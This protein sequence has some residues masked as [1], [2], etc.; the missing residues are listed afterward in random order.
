M[1]RRRERRKISALTTVT[2][3]GMRAMRPARSLALLS[4]LTAVGQ[5]GVVAMIFGALAERTAGV[6][7][8]GA[9]ALAF[10]LL[11]LIRHFLDQ[12]AGRRA[13]AVGQEVVHRLRG[14]VL[15]LQSRRS[16]ALTERATSAA[17]AT[18]VGQG[19]DQLLPWFTRYAMAEIRVYVMPL[20]ILAILLP[21]SWVAALI[22]IMTGP[23]IP[24]FMALIGYA[25]RDATDLQ[26]SES[27][28]LNSAVL[29]WLNASADL[30]LLD[31]SERVVEAFAAAA[32]R[33]RSRTFIV[34]RIAFL[35]SS[36]LE[37]FAALGVALVAVYIGFSLLGSFSFGTWGNPMTLAGGMLILLLVPEFFQPLRDLAAAWHDKAAA[38]AVA[39]QILALRDEPALPILGSGGAA[40]PLRGPLLVE[41]RGLQVRRGSQ[42]PIC[43]PDF[44]IEA[45]QRVAL[46]GP[47]GAGKTTLLALIAGLQTAD[48]GQIFVCGHPL[49]DDNADAWRMRLAYAGQFPHLFH[50]SLR[51]NIG[52][53]DLHPDPARVASAIVDAGVGDILQTLPRAELTR[54]GENGA[55]VSGGEAR[56]L[57]LARAFYAGAEALLADEP[58]AD[59]DDETADRVIE[60]LLALCA[61]GTTLIVASHDDRLLRHLDC[62]IQLGVET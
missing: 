61:N 51:A 7:D 22:L 43:F 30:R 60:T 10:L 5:G 23:L 16:S 9:A 38:E 42:K 29:E 35:S 15:T 31:G 34:L 4:S 6:P 14:E 32:E 19:L 2:E 58:T 40:V 28:S 26:L 57:T 52:L 3:S 46:V 13:F 21:I 49:S 50:M 55:G 45:G 37:L 53:C 1:T 18:L 24:L 33:L 17:T 20:V 54:L 56:R 41:A 12:W 8:V 47:S 11:G 27:L 39:T 25:A 36:V 62:R 44:R 48:A 59:L